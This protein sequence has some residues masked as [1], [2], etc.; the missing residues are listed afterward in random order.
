MGPVRFWLISPPPLLE[1]GHFLK[2]TESGW[3]LGTFTK[4]RIRAKYPL[5]TLSCISAANLERIQA[6]GLPS[7]ELEGTVKQKPK[8]RMN[9]SRERGRNS[10]KCQSN[11]VISNKVTATGSDPPSL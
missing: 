3:G 7:G 8:I 11:S 9:F 5:Y 2:M 4:H 10:K 6:K 1:G